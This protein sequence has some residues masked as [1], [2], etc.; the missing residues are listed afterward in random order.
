L[1]VTNSLNNNNNNNNLAKFI[2]ENIKIQLNEVHHTL[3]DFAVV[4]NLD[5]DLCHSGAARR[6]DSAWWSLNRRG[7]AKV[8]WTYNR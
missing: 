3:L 6:S 8:D 5:G 2:V 4:A 7:A 1:R